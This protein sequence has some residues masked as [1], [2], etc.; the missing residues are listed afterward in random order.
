MNRRTFLAS[1]AAGAAGMSAL[2]G[3]AFGKGQGPPTTTPPQGRGGQGGGRGP[4]APANVAAAKLARVSLMTLNF[5]NM[6]KFPWTQNP[7]ETQTMSVLDLPQMYRDAY[8]VNHIFS[9]RS[10]PGNGYG[11]PMPSKRHSTTGGG[12]HA[13]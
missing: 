11:K 10:L 9:N 7:N 13:V 4:G 6:L 5:S 12:T 2:G 8:G 3:A 1:T